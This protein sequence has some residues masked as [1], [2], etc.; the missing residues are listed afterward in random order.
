MYFT[1]LLANICV[2]VCVCVC[3]GVCI[4]IYIFVKFDSLAF[5]KIWLDY[6][7]ISG[8]WHHDHLSIYTIK[9]KVLYVAWHLC[10][11]SQRFYGKAE[12]ETMCWPNFWPP[13][14]QGKHTYTPFLHIFRHINYFTIK[15]ISGWGEPELTL[16]PSTKGTRKVSTERPEMFFTVNNT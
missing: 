13:K 14:L 2:C 9:Y 15:D 6:N 5:G 12:S 11:K 16:E 1:I 7:L 4:Y 3:V 8:S 10:L